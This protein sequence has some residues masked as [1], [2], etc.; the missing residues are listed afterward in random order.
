MPVAIPVLAVV[1][2]C[3]GTTNQNCTYFQSS[4]VAAG[5]CSIRIC[6][7]S[8]DIC[9]VGQKS[10]APMSYEYVML[11]ISFCPCNNDLC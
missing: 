11:D 6:K 8:T 3:G 10:F 5:M 4:A 1:L 2:G 9:Q 7:C